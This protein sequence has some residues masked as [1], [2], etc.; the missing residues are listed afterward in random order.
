MKINADFRIL[1]ICSELKKRLARA[2]NFF[3]LSG[4]AMY[5]GQGMRTCRVGTG[6]VHIYVDAFV[7][8]YICF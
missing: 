6:C 1:M 4:M 7:H 2:K 5:A 8:M 3:I